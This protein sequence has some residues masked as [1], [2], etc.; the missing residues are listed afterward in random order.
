MG[1]R[2]NYCISNFFLDVHFSCDNQFK[3][4]KNLNKHMKNVHEEKNLKCNNCSYTTND[5]FNM[6]RHTESCNKRKSLQD[7]QDTNRAREEV[8][9]DNQP[10]NEDI[11]SDDT[12]TCFNGTLQTQ[13]FYCN[14]QY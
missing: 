11:V 4:L 2:N 9:S 3:E 6:E 14:F 13:I 8:H 10:P 12:E 5:Q 7:E 1:C